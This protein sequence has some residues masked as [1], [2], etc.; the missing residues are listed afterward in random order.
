MPQCDFFSK[1][2]EGK[3]PVKSVYIMTDKI[4]KNINKSDN[5]FTKIVHNNVFLTSRRF[6][7]L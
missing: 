5:F 7:T 6:V 1:E 3:R 2:D 4:W